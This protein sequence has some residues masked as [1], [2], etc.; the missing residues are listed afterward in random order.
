MFF[1]CAQQTIPKFKVLK[2]LVFISSVL[3]DSHLGWAQWGGS[4]PGLVWDHSFGSSG[5][6]A[7]LCLI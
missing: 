6:R 2:G 3:W 5:L 4:P 7:R 1:N